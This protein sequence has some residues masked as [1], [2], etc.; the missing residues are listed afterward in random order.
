LG[1]NGVQEIMSHPWFNGLDW[2][3]NIDSKGPLFE[4]TI[5]ERSKNMEDE[6]MFQSFG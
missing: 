6:T 3:I 5:L 2:T 1:K 4:N